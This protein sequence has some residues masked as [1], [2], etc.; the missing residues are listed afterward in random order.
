MAASRDGVTMR[1]RKRYFSEI[2]FACICLAV[3]GVVSTTAS[4]PQLFIA[5]AILILIFCSREIRRAWV[6]FI[7]I[8][9]DNFTISEGGTN[10]WAWRV[11]RREITY[12][13]I[14]GNTMTIQTG[15]SEC[16]VSLSGYP[17]SA[18]RR[19]INELQRKR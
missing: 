9:K 19:I 17:L 5:G 6:S 13:G 18:S 8:S 7:E 3:L 12:C 11:P 1:I 16:I 4:R 2:I 15:H 10:G 14:E